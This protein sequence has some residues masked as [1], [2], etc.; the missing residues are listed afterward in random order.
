MP[1]SVEYVFASPTSSFILRVRLT[2]FFQDKKNKSNF[3]FQQKKIKTS[4]LEKKKLCFPLEDGL[5]G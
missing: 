5:D 2:A 1:F 4:T 3:F